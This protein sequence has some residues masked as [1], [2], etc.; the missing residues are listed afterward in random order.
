M[1]ITA[2]DINSTK[3]IGNVLSDFKD[4][5]I[6]SKRGQ[7]FIDM[8]LQS[9][10]DP[11]I[12]TTDLDNLRQELVSL[13]GIP[14]SYL[15]IQE[16]SDNR[17]QLVNVNSSLAYEISSMQHVFNE[18]LLDLIDRIAELTNFN[19]KP[20]KYIIIQL[21][22]PTVLMLQIVESTLVSVGNIFGVFKD[23]PGITLNPL[24]LLKRYVPYIDWDNM[25][26]EGE[27]LTVKNKVISSDEAAEVTTNLSGRP[28]F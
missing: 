15:N 16:Q 8:E 14:A 19:D 22:P 23:V 20:S 5:V 26:R 12:K 4:M 18:K 27:I 10:G 25:L 11:N 21:L 24:S 13:S 2:N 3:D 6:F 17:E 9:M 28:M 7:R 1:R